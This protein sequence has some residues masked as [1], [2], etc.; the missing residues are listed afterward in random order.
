MSQSRTC[1]TLQQ[2]R[3]GLGVLGPN[4]TAVGRTALHAV[5]FSSSRLR[6]H[7]VCKE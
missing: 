3:H 2:V 4:N 6:T 7:V 5:Q 1:L